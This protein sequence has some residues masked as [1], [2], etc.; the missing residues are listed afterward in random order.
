MGSLKIYKQGL[1]GRIADYIMMPIMYLLQGSIQESPQRTHYWN[2]LSLNIDQLKHLDDRSMISAKE[3]FGAHD[4]WLAFI[5]IFH[6]PL[7]GGWK[8]Y[9]LIEPSVKQEEWFVGWVAGDLAGMSRVPL[10]GSVRMLRGSSPVQWF[11]VDG[12]GNQID[13]QRV[14]DGMVGNVPTK[15]RKVP[16]L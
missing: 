16:L 14:E 1:I 3:D 8:H 6:I 2:N 13:L 9:V 5:P 7:F 12:N 10:T 4:R 15:H 11:G